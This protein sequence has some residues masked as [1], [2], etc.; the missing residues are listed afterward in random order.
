MD[1]RHRDAAELTAKLRGLRRRSGIST[2]QLAQRCGFSQS[3][4]SRIELGKTQPSIP[5]VMS[6]CDALGLRPNVKTSLLRLAASV[7]GPWRMTKGTTAQV[8]W[9][10]MKQ[11]AKSVRD[12]NYQLVPQFAQTPAY[13]L[14]MR[15]H[16]GTV[17]DN[18]FVANRMRDAALSYVAGYDRILVMHPSLLDRP[19]LRHREWIH[20]LHHVLD[21]FPHI[22]DGFAILPP[23]SPADGLSFTILDSSVMLVEGPHDWEISFDRERIR[24]AERQFRDAVEAAVWD[25][26]AFRLIEETVERNERTV[27][28]RTGSRTGRSTGSVFDSK[29]R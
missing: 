17:A 26:D 12:V 19:V 28:I 10:H 25:R 15:G 16:R 14:E 23:D 22:R 24:T 9:L 29:A 4:V 6:L 27:D 13:M 21:V 1:S 2:Y 7:N 20:Q 3:K 8:E 5:D 18:E 11:D